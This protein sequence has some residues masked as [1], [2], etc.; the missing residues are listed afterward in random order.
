MRGCFRT[1]ILDRGCRL[2]CDARRACVVGPEHAYSVEQEAHHSRIRW[3]PA[4]LRRA[5]G[6]LLRP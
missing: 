5:A 1:R 6:V 2:A 4:V 3:G